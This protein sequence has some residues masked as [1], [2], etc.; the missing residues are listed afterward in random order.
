[1]RIK[2]SSIILKTNKLL[3]TN[4]TFSTHCGKLKQEQTILK[5]RDK[6]RF[7]P[8][9]HCM[10]ELPAYYRTPCFPFSRCLWNIMYRIQSNQSIT[11][12]NSQITLKENG[13]W[14]SHALPSKSDAAPVQKVTVSSSRSFKEF[15]LTNS[16]LRI[17]NSKLIPG[18]ENQVLHLKHPMI[19]IAKQPLNSQPNN[20]TYQ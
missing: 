4:W 12:S 2:I 6:N 3:S 5:H 14:Y 13:S 11:A 18:V 7:E 8:T 20:I 19:H 1:M 17:T 10:I 15:K 16:M 9:R